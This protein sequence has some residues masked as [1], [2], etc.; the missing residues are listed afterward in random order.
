MPDSTDRYRIGAVSR[1]TGIPAVTLRA[2]ER[3]YGAV[4][5]ARDSG[6]SRLYSS[7]DVERLVLIKRLVDMGNAISTVATLA[8]EELRERVASDREQIRRSHEGIG[9]VRRTLAVAGSSLGGRMRDAA[10]SLT[11]LDLLS[12]QDTAAELGAD[13]RGSR[14]DVIVLEYPTLHAESLDEIRRLLRET[15]A[16]RAVV[17]YG[18]ARRA[19]IQ[20]LEAEDIIAMAA[21]VNLSELR[22]ICLAADIPVAAADEPSGAG[23]P[24]DVPAADPG[25]TLPARL[26]SS[27]ELLRLGNKATSIDCECPHHL[28]SL[29]RS[30]VG[31]ELYSA[32][33]EN[34]NDDDAA[35]HA[36]LQRTTANARAAMEQA[37]Q[38]VARAEGLLDD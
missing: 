15:R 34:R 1:L 5:A 30:L 4:Q 20:A 32:E 26:F 10:E 25:G 2:W 33:C 12:T 11:G 8:F 19:L 16:A 7:A 28:S 18:F 29:I 17:V 9:G 13:L 21:P 23:A 38:R 22:L 36:Y 3:R 35:L 31:F 24:A 6:G 27:Q 14:V 37:L